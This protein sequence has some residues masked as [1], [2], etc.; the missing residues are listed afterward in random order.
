MTNNGYAISTLYVIDTT[1]NTVT[2][3]VKV[4]IRPHGV[5]ISPDGTKVYVTNIDSGTVSV[6]DTVTNTVKDTINVGKAPYGVSVTPMEKK[7][8]CGEST[9]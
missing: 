5:A 3:R 4:G 2:A 6:V 9:Q 8:I 1:T 7:C